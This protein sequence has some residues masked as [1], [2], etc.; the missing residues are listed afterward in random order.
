MKSHILR[1]L[2]WALALGLAGA[3]AMAAAEVK[4]VHPENFADAGE[5]GRDRDQHLQQIA[6][7]LQRQAEKFAPGKQLTFEV[8][9]VDLAGEIEPVGRR[10][11]RLRV[12]RSV[13]SP[14][15]EFR[16]LIREANQPDRQGEAQLRDLGY[17]M[18]SSRY[19][20]SDPM[21][22]EKRMLDDWFQAEFVPP[23]R[24]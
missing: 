16:Y 5:S 15:I 17:Q 24:P 19:W 13:T 12:M 14:R 9:D 22:Y 11:E 8:T 3:P 2:C 4:F 10:M 7:H 1:K 18:R 6:E 20:D 21:R 23:K